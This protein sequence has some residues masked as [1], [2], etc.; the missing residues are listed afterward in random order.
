MTRIWETTVKIKVFFSALR[1]VGLSRMPLKFSKP[2]KDKVWRPV[3]T[4][5]TL[6]S[7][8]KPNGNAMSA[9]MYRIAGASMIGPSHSARSRRL[10]KPFHGCFFTPSPHPL[11]EGEGA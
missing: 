3:V 11:P 9:R 1:K 2:A 7:R 5:L 10:A 6:Y 4:S 8:A